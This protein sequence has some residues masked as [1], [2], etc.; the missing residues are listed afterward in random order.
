MQRRCDG[1]AV[2]NSGVERGD[3]SS[4]GGEGGD[5]GEADNIGL[6]EISHIIVHKNNLCY[7]QPNGRYTLSCNLRARVWLKFKRVARLC[8]TEAI[9]LIEIYERFLLY[10]KRQSIFDRKSR[11]I[12][13]PQKKVR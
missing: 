2:G 10:P 11:F 1:G 13:I 7:F 6:T 9:F 4:G 12:L 8:P 5:G 3:E